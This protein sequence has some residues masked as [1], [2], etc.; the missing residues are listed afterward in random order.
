LAHGRRVQ[1]HQRICRQTPGSIGDL[2]TMAPTRL[3]DCPTVILVGR[4]M[5]S[6]YVKVA[7]FTVACAFQALARGIHVRA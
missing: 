2:A 7:I 5:L 6:T 3:P 1:E 4:R